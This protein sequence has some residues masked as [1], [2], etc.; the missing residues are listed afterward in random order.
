MKGTQFG[1]IQ[2]S[3][4]LLVLS[5]FISGCS[6]LATG[7]YFGQISPPKENVM[8]YVSGGEIESLDPPI[9]NSQPDARILIALFDGLV[10]YHPITMEP[11]PGIAESWEVSPDGTEY[12]FHLRN[13]AKF[14]NG[15]PI[16]ASDFVYSLRRG[17]S[18]E[19]ASRNAYLGYSVKYSEA[20]NGVRSF[21]KDPSGTFLLKKDF[22]PKKE[23]VTEAPAEEPKADNFGADTEFHRFLDGPERLA[24]PS[25][26]KERN[27]LLEKNPK[28]KAAVQGKE[29]VPVKAEDIGLEAVDDYTLRIKLFQP[30]PYFVGLLA[31]QFF[32]VVPRKI[33]EKYGNNWTRTENIVTAGA[34][35]L[36][37]HRPYD[38]LK[39]VRDPNNWDAAN[40]KLDGIEFYP[41]DE[42]TTMMNLY[43]AGSVDALYNHTVPAAWFEQI[44][45]Y[46]A[47][48]SL[49]P[50]VATEFYVMNVKK[51]P[52]D[53]I[54]VRQAF[55][56]A[57]DREALAKFRKTIKPSVDMTPEGVFPKYEAV[58]DRVFA[59]ELKKIGSS[60]EEWK[61]RIFDPEKARKLLTEAGFNV[62]AA[63]DGFSCPSFPVDKTNITYN[64]A[65][66]N[67]AVAEFIQAQWKQNLGVTIPLK[68]MEFRTFLPLLN[69]VDYEGFARRGWVGDYM[70]PYTFLSLYYTEGNES[71]TGWWDPKFDRMLDAANNS[72][73]PEKRFEK[74][75]EAEFFVMQQQVIIPLATQATS[76]MKKPYVK[77]FYPNPGTLEPWKFVYIERDP[78]KW[79]TNMSTI[80]KDEDPAVTA[81]LDQLMATQ[82]EMEKSKAAQMPDQKTAE[83]K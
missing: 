58:R 80:M 41:L 53:K 33:I 13:N 50:E 43:K 62:S 67:K 63:G 15:D 35:K 81:Q 64:T 71:A 59:E 24:V 73:D 61:A 45:Q 5:S 37:I 25:D 34:F 4:A 42:A 83:A 6:T 79:T 68:N 44:S 77:G 14:S 66:S 40:V 69:K 60:M 51:A 57:V 47:E 2:L 20:Y 48:Y 75:A 30:A 23:G 21:V 3:L 11:I 16:T 9:T 10:E 65:E 31:H 49:H 22:E 7:R 28:L 74:L 1:R 76:W 72:V 82:V 32:R 12:L 18:P 52:M 8:R 27:A 56:L 29:L 70:D 55:S 36:A 54:K 19:L 38:V 78:N 17:F 39:V 26:E 46:K